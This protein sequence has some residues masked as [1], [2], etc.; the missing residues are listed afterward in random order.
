MVDSRDKGVV[1]DLWN[2]LVYESEYPNPVVQM[3]KMLGIADRPN[4]HVLI[5]RAYMTDPVSGIEEALKR[6][7]RLVPLP[8]IDPE[9]YVEMFQKHDGTIRLF[10]DVLPC[11]QSLRP[12]YR[13]GLLTNTQS[14]GLEFIKETN[15][16]ELF[17]V[18]CMSFECGFL[19]PDPEIF[20]CV[21]SRLDLPPKSLTM[22]GDNLE[23][24]VLAAEAEGWSGIL[25]KRTYGALSHSESGSHI[26]TVRSLSKIE[27]FLQD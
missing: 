4:W 18:T 2:T 19:K 24:D 17:D 23:T 21:A 15:L 12:N 27:P 8:S 9:P 7:E 26:R 5:E 6:L 14:F 3:A 25:V 1:F 20:R 22:V 11:L 16:F 10:D 13:L